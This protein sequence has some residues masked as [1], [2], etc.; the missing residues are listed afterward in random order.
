MRVVATSLPKSGTH[1]LVRLLELLEFQERKPS[2][3]ASL[4]RIT[5]RNP[6]R[7]ILKKSR[8]WHSN[9]DGDA[10][11]MVDLDEPENRVRRQWLCRVLHAVP[12][13]SFLKAHL[14]YSVEMESLLLSFGFKILFI[15]RDPRDVAVS[16]CNYV[17]KN[18][19]HPLYGH[20]RMLPDYP[21][22]IR[23]VLNG[24]ATPHGFIFSPLDHQLRNVLGW[25]R[26]KRTLNVRFEDLIGPNGGGN[27]AVQR[28]T[29]LRICEHLDVSTTSIYLG[30][31]AEQV[32]Y[33]KART[34]HKG[35]IGSW[36]EYLDKE[37]LDTFEQHVGHLM[38]ELGYAI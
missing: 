5:E 17:S 30:H 13:H 28:Q 14:P 12:D 18:A 23:A 10:G 35:A 22:R 6:I 8:L 38:G 34:F 26:S 2:L 25:W 29:V 16:Y 24:C 3:M 21:S 32:F 36:K 11:L 4:V 33:C 1:L 20:F 31:V 7:R 15:I 9:R 19:R 37:M 27:E